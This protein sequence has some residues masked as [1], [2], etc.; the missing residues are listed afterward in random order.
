IEKRLDQAIEDLKNKGEPCSLGY[1]DLDHFKRINGLFG[2]TSGDDILTQITQRLRKVLSKQQSLGR[3]GSDEFIILFPN[4]DAPAARRT[5]EQII[6]A[7]NGSSYQV[8]HRSF[9]VRSAMGVVEL[10]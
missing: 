10:H 8:G 5:A 3:I 7:L 2:H 6:I 1:M 4:M 9:N